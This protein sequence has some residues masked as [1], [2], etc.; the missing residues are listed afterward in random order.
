MTN[1]RLVQ[2]GG[3]IGVP[4]AAQTTGGLAGKRG[5]DMDDP[6]CSIRGCDGSNYA[7]GWCCRHYE[8][9]RVHGD[10][11]YPGV[12]TVERFWRSFERDPNT[13]CWNWR[14]PR[15]NGYGRFDVTHADRR[16]AHRYSY[17]LLVE[18]IPAG[19]TIDH[20]CRNPRCVNPAHLEPVDSRE[21]VR[22]AWMTPLPD[23]T[24]RDPD[25]FCIRGHPLEPPNV[26]YIRRPRS[27]PTKTC[28]TCLHE[29]A[30]RSRERCKN[31]DVG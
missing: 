31:R 29:M 28:L 19:L 24:L 1:V 3:Y 7:R 22:R 26:I 4:R 20:L 12:S 13:G 23:G 21:N 15:T 6:T 16:K 25:K 5:P 2:S 18:P 27:K 9:W 8:V 14:R 17:E 30:R 10:P 11:L